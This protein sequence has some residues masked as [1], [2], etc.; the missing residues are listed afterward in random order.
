M[1]LKRMSPKQGIQANFAQKQQE[2]KTTISTSKTT[3]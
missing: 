3:C 1:F 2:K